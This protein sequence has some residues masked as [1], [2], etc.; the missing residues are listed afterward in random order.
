[1]IKKEK[2]LSYYLA[3]LKRA[4]HED[5]VPAD[6]DIIDYL[7]KHGHISPHVKLVLLGTDPKRVEPEA[8]ASNSADA[9]VQ[10]K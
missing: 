2:R 7:L 3:E 5:K 10:P 9:D 8:T 6:K 4:I 1:M